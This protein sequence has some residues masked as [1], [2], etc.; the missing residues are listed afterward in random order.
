M[1]KQDVPQDIG[2]AEGLKEVCYAVDDTGR[3]VLVPSAGW[4]PKN[5]TNH[6]AWQLIEEQQRDVATQVLEGRQ[7]PIAYYMT[8]NLMDVGLLAQYVGFFRWRVRR[9]LKPRVF[10]KLAPAVLE[11]YAKVF[12]ITVEQL[13]D[14]RQIGNNVP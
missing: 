7:S 13:T 10:R 1:R 14:Q 6:Q 9:H 3:Y 11:K 5:V 2:I 8:K 4:E 12:G